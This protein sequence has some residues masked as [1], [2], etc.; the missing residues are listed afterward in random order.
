MMVK[1]NDEKT[2]GMIQYILLY[3]ADM[4]HDDLREVCKFVC[5]T[6]RRRYRIEAR[7]A[8]SR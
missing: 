8:K 5:R 3:I 7:E 2:Q 1:V 4:N 6:A